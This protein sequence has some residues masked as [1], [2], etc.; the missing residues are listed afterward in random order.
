MGYDLVCAICSGLVEQ[1]NCATC[2]V[3]RER[4]RAQR[5]LPAGLLLAASAVVGVLA[6]VLR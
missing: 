2:R 4:L 3:S 1:G 6:L 5:T